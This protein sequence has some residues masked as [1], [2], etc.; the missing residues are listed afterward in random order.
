MQ[1]S[2]EVGISTALLDPPYLRSP[3]HPIEMKILASEI[4]CEGEEK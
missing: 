4:N 1:Q 2:N 3:M